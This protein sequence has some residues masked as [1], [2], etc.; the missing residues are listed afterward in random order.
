MFGD[1]I[2][3]AFRE[4]KHTWD[5]Q[6]IMNP[7]KIIDTPPMTEN[8]RYGAAYEPLHLET[9]LDFTSD[10]GFSGA[11]EMCNGM[12]ACRKLDGTM[13]P[14]FMATRDEE[15]STRGRANLLRAHCRGECP[16]GRRDRLPTSGCMTLWICAWNAKPAKPSANRA[17]IWPS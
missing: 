6:D 16:R 11:V 17:L 15:H 13:C 8:L 4:L 2:Y 10:F 7:G 9:K 14:S 3:N 12:G 1:R 5:P